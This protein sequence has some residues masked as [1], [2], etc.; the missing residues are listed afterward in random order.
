MQSSRVRVP[1]E[2]P[3][4]PESPGIFLRPLVPFRAAREGFRAFLEA[5]GFAESGTVLL[6]AYVGW[7]SREGSGVFD[8]VRETGARWSFYPVGEDLSIDLKALAGLLADRG[9]YL[10]VLIHYFGYPAIGASAASRMV[11]RTGGVVLEDEAHAL[12]TDWI[13]GVTGR[14]GD[15]AIFSFHKMLPTSSGGG[16]AL[17]SG[18]A[19]ALVERLSNWPTRKPLPLDPLGYDLKAIARV[20]RGNAAE[21]A[22]LLAPLS[23][24]LEP[25]F[26]MAPPGVVPQTFPVLVKRGSRDD[27]YT[28]MNG[29]GFGAVSLY[30]T[31]IP[32]IEP[33]RYPV[34]HAL[35]KRILNLPVHQDIPTGGLDVMT[36]WLSKWAA[37]T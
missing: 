19:P 9:P 26:A 7:S 33:E 8:P 25:L 5:T 34:S 22:K 23:S 28:E 30:H 27:L 31:M 4:K 3:K 36:R 24:H 20:R 14:L 2:I 32:E 21:L 17:A 35:S 15:A 10:L 29:A 13:G 6:P 1:V 18:A 11:R 12:L 16:L 37:R